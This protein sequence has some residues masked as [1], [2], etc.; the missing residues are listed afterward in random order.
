MPRGRATP[1]DDAPVVDAATI[2]QRVRLLE[3]TV[4]RRVDGILHGHHQGL[5]PGQGSEPGEARGYE[6]GDDVRRIDW[7]ATART[8]MVHVRDQVADRALDAWIVLD[9]SATLRFGTALTT[10]DDVAVS[11]AAAIGF[12]T[13]RHRNRIGA[14][15]VSGSHIDVI[16]PRPGRDQIRA[17]LSR[18]I[19]AVASP[20]TE[21]SALATALRDLAAIARRRGFVAVISDFLA[22]DWA[23][24]ITVLGRRH[25]L[26]A[27]EVLDP[28][29]EELSPWGQ[30]TLR[31]PA[32]GRRREVRLTPDICERYRE[33]AQAQRTSIRDAL[34]RS[35]ASHLLIR[36]DTDW[37]ASVVGHVTKRPHQGL[38]R[39]PAGL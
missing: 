23:G 14:M 25:E 24:P 22:P 34:L 12:L 30:M 16:P 27:V 3:L 10:K 2:A 33:A 6:P 18:M 17:I 11:A 31:D 7:N 13:A 5:V 1:G 20:P 19:T 26:L 8:G 4:Q 32:T 29:E 15:I 37:I 9:A 36:T 38:A 28:R 35:G 21:V 39:V